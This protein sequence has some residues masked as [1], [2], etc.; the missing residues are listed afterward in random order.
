MRGLS[1]GIVVVTDRALAWWGGGRRWPTVIPRDAITGAEPVEAA[2][3]E[4]LRVAHG[5]AATVLGLVEPPGR[6]AE[7]AALL[8][9]GL[10]GP[11]GLDALVA[12][13]PDAG[14]TWQ[15]KRELELVRDLWRERE[16]GE[17]LALGFVGGKRGALVLTDDRLLW[18]SRKADPVVLERA[19]IAGVT[20]KRVLGVIRLDLAL[21]GGGAQ[22]FDAVEPR[23]RAEA[24]AAALQR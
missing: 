13:E 16:A 21:D 19:A 12:A 22:R 18:A 24:L 23:E 6:A 1:G 9:A 14:I 2:G 4:E 3:S 15:L 20:A 10:P 5:G 8:A 11:S 7:L 17:L